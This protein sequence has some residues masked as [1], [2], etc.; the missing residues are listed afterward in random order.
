MLAL[1]ITSAFAGVSG[2]YV[3]Q[4]A[5]SR[6]E[7]R[8]NRIA[9]PYSL[10]VVTMLNV[11]LTN[12]SHEP[13]IPDFFVKPSCP[14]LPMLW[15]SNTNA[16]LAG[17]SRA[18]YLVVATDAN[19]GIPRG[20]QFWVLVYDSQTGDLAGQSKL[21]FADIS[22]PSVVNPDFTWWLLDASLG[23]QVPYGWKVYPAGIQ[24]PVGGIGP[25]NRTFDSGV[26]MRLNYSS[27]TGP[28]R[29]AIT[30]RL[31]FNETKL[32]LS[33][34][35]SFTNNP[36]GTVTLG[37]QVSDNT[38][39]VFFLF[40]SVATLE[41]VASYSENVTVTIPIKPLTWSSLVLDPQAVWTAQ[42]WAKPTTVEFSLYFQTSLF[43]YYFANIKELSLSQVPSRA[44]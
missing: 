11:T 5:S 20:T 8:I 17:S 28:S 15:K 2:A 9:D 32:S 41:T 39:R 1:A 19:A 4:I 21:L 25:F 35:Q 22:R 31:L 14:C 42:G 36:P 37:A 33:A 13:I 27:L 44:R 3:S 38:H 26:Q 18:S 34:Y 43:G 7:I 40:S 29:I 16:T 24:G 12:T 6:A 10:G 23:Q 30:Q